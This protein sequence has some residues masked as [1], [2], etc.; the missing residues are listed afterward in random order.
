MSEHGRASPDRNTRV[1]RRTKHRLI[2]RIA[3]SQAMNPVDHVLRMR[4]SMFARGLWTTWSAWRA[5]VIVDLSSRVKTTGLNSTVVERLPMKRH[6]QICPQPGAQNCGSEPRNIRVFGRF[7]WT[8]RAPRSRTKTA[9]PLE[10]I[11]LEGR[12]IKREHFNKCVA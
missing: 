6:H 4:S 11:L 5:F 7:G 9:T 2:S 3:F 8:F 12:S 10:Q 1:G